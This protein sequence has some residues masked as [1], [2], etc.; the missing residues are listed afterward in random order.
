MTDEEQ[1]K[2]LVGFSED[3]ARSPPPV[4]V[5]RDRNISDILRAADRIYERWLE[6][7]DKPQRH[8]MTRLVQGAPGSGKSTLIEQVQRLAGQG[9]APS[10][11]RHLALFL[12]ASEPSDSKGLEG[13]IREQVPN[14]LLASVAGAG[15]KLLS[16][17]ATGSARPASGPADQAERSVLKAGERRFPGTLL[18]M[19][20][21]AQQ[22]APYSP[23]AN[24]LRTLHQALHTLPIL[25]VFAG[26]GHLRPHLKR[27]G[28]GISRFAGPECIHAIGAISS[29]ES[30]ALL[31]GWLDHFEVEAKPDDLSRWKAAMRHDAQG[32]AMHTYDFLSPLAR[33]LADSPHPR[34]LSA[35]DMKVVRQAAAERR[36]GHYV[37][38]YEEE[39]G[40]LA[41]RPDC[42]ASL[43]ARLRITGPQTRAEVANSIKAAFNERTEQGEESW[44]Q[45]LT[46]RGFLQNV[47]SRKGR[48]L[49]KHACPIPSLASY[50]TASMLP[51]H[52]E[53]Y[54]GDA[55]A[56]A[57]C[58]RDDPSAIG[59]A[60][61]MGRTALHVAAEGRWSDVADLLIQAGADP[62]AKD[63]QG[64]TP[65][66]TWPEQGWSGS[67]ARSERPALD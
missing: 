3:G 32:W 29:T 37:E 39:G 53:A 40:A 10:G 23:E 8:G 44:H 57:E 4:F 28:I 63:A 35:I 14:A 41:K 49:P 27:K 50:A 64:A 33:T 54:A 48:A 26:L 21:E 42:V 15:V 5:G 30:D 18:V 66:Q 56:V 16:T 31:E 45:E 43:M 61:D 20:D 12:S 36:I 22:V 58:L 55:A 19:V 51:L 59:L 11:T 62:S 60:D 2:K 38:R 1:R 9:A 34:Q 52:L 6:D 47:P 25:P 13:R 67:G 65:A 7:R 17:I 46:E 24:A